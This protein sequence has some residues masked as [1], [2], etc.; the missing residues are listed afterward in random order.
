M[1]TTIVVSCLQRKCI[2]FLAVYLQ[3]YRSHIFWLDY[4]HRF[5]SLYCKNCFFSRH[6][7]CPLPKNNFLNCTQ[8]FGGYNLFSYS[9][10]QVVRLE[11]L[12]QLQKARIALS[13]TQSLIYSYLIYRIQFL[14]LNHLIVVYCNRR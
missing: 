11:T 6:W 2:L 9:L 12:L 3:T 10:L 7:V 5:V 8:K 1:D 14:H 13:L 4:R